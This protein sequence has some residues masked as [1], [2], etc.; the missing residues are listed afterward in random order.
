MFICKGGLAL[1]LSGGIVHCT[2]YTHDLVQVR[3]PGCHVHWQEGDVCIA[4]GWS[5]R[6][7]Y[8]SLLPKTLTGDFNCKLCCTAPCNSPWCRDQRWAW[9]TLG[10]HTT[11]W[12]TSFA[13]SISVPSPFL[14][15]ENNGSCF[16]K[17]CDCSSEV[18]IS[19]WGCWEGRSWSGLC[20][21]LLMLG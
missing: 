12:L 3:V 7:W 17:S 4:H 9:F 19:H 1:G 13:F 2:V 10:L 6:P 21:L 14:Y 20:S 18:T 15:R 8:S 5:I 11:V 16:M